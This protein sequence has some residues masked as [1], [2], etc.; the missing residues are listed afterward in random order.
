M[1]LNNIFLSQN[2]GVKRA[3]NSPSPVNKKPKLATTPLEENGT[4]RSVKVKSF[5]ELL[6]R[7]AVQRP[8]S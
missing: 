8:V 2:S 4:Y 6:K 5:E 7:P 1:L 3:A